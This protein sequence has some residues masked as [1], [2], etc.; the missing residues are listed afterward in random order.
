M[1]RLED[2]EESDWESEEQEL[3]EEEECSRDFSRIFPREWLT[4]R[5]QVSELRKHTDISWNALAVIAVTAEGRRDSQ[6]A[7]RVIELLQPAL[8]SGF[9]AAKAIVALT[10]KELRISFLKDEEKE[11]LRGLFCADALIAFCVSLIDLLKA[12]P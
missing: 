12:M 6:E 3:Q 1:K 11:R 9:E 7:I 10:S 8:E 2:E 4:P 5:R